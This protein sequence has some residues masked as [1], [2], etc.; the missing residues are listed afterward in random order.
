MD[1]K[2]K[3]NAEPT[4]GQ[5]LRQI[6]RER[7]LT[8]AEVSE[9]SGVSISTLSRLENDRTSLNF[10]NVLQLI[11]GLNI[12]LSSLIGPRE[13][14]Y[15]GR[16][17]I[18]RSG[19][20]RFFETPQLVFE[21]LCGDL[22]QKRNVFWRVQVKARSLDDYD[23]Y[24]RHPGEEFISVVKGTLILCTELYEDT[25]L[26]QGDSIFFDSAMGHAYISG[27]RGNAVILMSNTISRSPLEGF[28]DDG[29]GGVGD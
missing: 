12:P 1:L 21:V 4:V 18:T 24:K 5:R 2:V 28:V 13:D 3:K 9:R 22:T 26:K 15:S 6:R 27:G 23:D 7:D 10:N 14:S 11:E 25:T 17:S 16:R 20:G 8:L 29:L 19:G